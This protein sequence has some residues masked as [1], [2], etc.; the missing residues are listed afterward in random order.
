MKYRIL[1][2][3]GINIILIIAATSC[4]TTENLVDESTVAVINPEA[5]CLKK[6]NHYYF[7]LENNIT[8]FQLY[9]FNKIHQSGKNIILPISN[10]SEI[11]NSVVEPKKN[12]TIYICIPNFTIESKMKINQQFEIKPAFSKKTYDSYV[13]DKIGDMKSKNNFER[14]LT[15]RLA[16]KVNF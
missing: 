12:K 8:S 10:A 9:P 11:I 5:K 16:L 13:V 2:F 4:T 1:I 6:E 3:A 14:K 15:I 7:P